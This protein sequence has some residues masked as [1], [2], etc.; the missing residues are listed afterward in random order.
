[1]PLQD[2]VMINNT[3]LPQIA[4]HKLEAIQVNIFQK[5]CDT[6]PSNTQKTEVKTPTTPFEGIFQ[7]LRVQRLKTLFWI[8]GKAKTQLNSFLFQYRDP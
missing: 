2:V 1:M 5:L 3:T 7:K 4:T 6:D 8:Q